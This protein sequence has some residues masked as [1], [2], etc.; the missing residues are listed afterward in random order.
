MAGTVPPHE[1][2]VLVSRAELFATGIHH[3][4]PDLLYTYKRITPRLKPEMITYHDY[5]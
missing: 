4:V 1:A 5:R 3:G 2:G